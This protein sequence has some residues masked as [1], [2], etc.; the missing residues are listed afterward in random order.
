MAHQSFGSGEGGGFN[1]ITKEYKANPTLENYVRLRRDD[2]DAEI[3][4]SVIGGFES[5]FYMRDELERHE[6]RPSIP[7]RRRA[8]Q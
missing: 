3:E 8:T 2:P 6:I 1:D 4:V 5:M 7:T